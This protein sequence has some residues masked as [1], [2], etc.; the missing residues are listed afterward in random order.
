MKLNLTVVG[1]NL[2]ADKGWIRGRMDLWRKNDGEMEH[3]CTPIFKPKQKTFCLPNT[4]LW[5]TKL[6][7]AGI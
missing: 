1:K 7:A 3:K 4:E 6:V 5:A 2:V